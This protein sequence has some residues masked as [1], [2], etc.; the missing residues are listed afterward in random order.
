MAAAEATSCRTEISLGL[1]IYDL[2]QN[3]VLGGYPGSVLI[4]DNNLSRL[5]KAQEFQ[6][7]VREQYGIETRTPDGVNSA[8]TDFVSEAG[9][10][11][12]ITNRPPAS[13]LI[14]IVIDHP[15]FCLRQA[16]PHPRSPYQQRPPFPS[17]TNH[18]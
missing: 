4:I 10:G 11:I 17:M 8:S 2:N 9:P 15:Q 1:A 18:M 12:I 6:G 3:K 14:V 5:D 16:T 7:T 13:F